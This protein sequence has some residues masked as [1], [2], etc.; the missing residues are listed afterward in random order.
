MQVSLTQGESETVKG[1]NSYLFHKAKEHKNIL[2]ADDAR[3][4]DLY[5]RAA[6]HRARVLDMSPSF[7]LRIPI[8]EP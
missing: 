2:D 5:R 1:I 4:S 3:A 7:A 8:I 6:R